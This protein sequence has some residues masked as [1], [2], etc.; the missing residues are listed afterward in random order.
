MKRVRLQLEYFEMKKLHIDFFTSRKKIEP[1][2]NMKLDV[3]IRLNK[4]TNKPRH[5]KLLLSIK[6]DPEPKIGYQVRAD[7]IGCFYVP[8]PILKEVMESLVKGNGTL[9]LY[10]I[11]RG[12]L[13]VF[14][15][16]F[17]GGKLTLPTI[18][19]PPITSKRT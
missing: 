9:I 1:D 6:V 5:F 17:P 19:I 15:G 14:T 2:V 18:P 11:L 16:S 4:I 13:A 10:G 7:I 8:E 3:K 12:E